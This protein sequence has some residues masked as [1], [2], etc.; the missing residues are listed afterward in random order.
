MNTEF[1]LELFLDCSL[2]P[3]HLSSVEVKSHFY[4]QSEFK[5]KQ[6]NN[7]CYTFSSTCS[8]CCCGTVTSAP[9]V[10]TLKSPAT[11]SSGQRWSTEPECP[12]GETPI[13]S[14]VTSCNAVNCYLNFSNTYVR[15][16]YQTWDGGILNNN[17]LISK[18][19]KSTYQMC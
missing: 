2:G 7:V 3:H 11:S 16:I 4:S 8:G 18:E 13:V 19:M 6:A 15:I 9:T 1:Y 17:T 10:I 12:A 14:S 5:P